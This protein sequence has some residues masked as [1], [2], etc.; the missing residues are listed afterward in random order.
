M[1][2][3]ALVFVADPNGSSPVRGELSDELIQSFAETKLQST[4]TA[5]VVLNKDLPDFL[6]FKDLVIDRGRKHEAKPLAKLLL[7]HTKIPFINGSYESAGQLVR[8][9]RTLLENAFAKDDHNLYVI[10][11]S[12][13]ILDELWDRA[14]S[15]K[16]S[17]QLV[18]KERSRATGKPKSDSP[19]SSQLLLQLLPRR[20]IPQALLQT[21]VGSSAEVQLVRQ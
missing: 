13:K 8:S 20:D 17:E 11:T 12:E 15:E 10:G 6:R 2:A 19:L 1:G 9:V 16:T 4:P 21:F 18:S 3:R 7:G 5:F 14:G